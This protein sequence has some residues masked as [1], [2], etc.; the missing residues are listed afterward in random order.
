MKTRVVLLGLFIALTSSAAT[1]A[2]E[3]GSTPGAIAD[4]GSYQ[5]SMEL[6]RQEQQQYEQQ[7]QQNDQMLQRLN[8]NY[9]QYA[10]TGSGVR[11]SA[12]GT[13]TAK[14]NP[15]VDW[16][17]KPPLAAASNPLL[18]RWQQVA[19]KGVSGQQLGAAA[20]LPGTADVAASLLNS[21]LAGGCKS[22]FGSGV[23]A[24]E[25]DKLQWVAPD[26]HEEILNNVAYRASGSE[27]VVL[28]RD[29]G[30]I[31][32]LIFGFPAHDHAVVAFFNCTMSRVGA[33]TVASSSALSSP[34]PGASSVG[35]TP[36]GTDAA[37]ARAAP[38]TAG[39]ASVRLQVGIAAPGSFTP[40]PGITLWLTP[41]NPAD[42]MAR[43]KLLPLGASLTNQLVADCTNGPACD[44][45]LKV[46]TAKALGSV[47]TDAAGRAQTPPVA[48]G[49]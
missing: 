44:R 46:M 40:L 11:G 8:D 1:R 42:A 15:P 41:D 23:V 34:K 49:H 2:Q 21:T 28:S 16:W 30:A 17:S 33:K 5:G 24:F 31:P 9:Q 35:K 6:Q 26:G 38:A 14:R 3:E 45:D 22:M 18:G 32:A 36:V 25:A 13:T 47:V 43:A 27:V 48:A 4:P 7:Q 19:A 12:G 20:V 10:P 37:P 29:P 39:N